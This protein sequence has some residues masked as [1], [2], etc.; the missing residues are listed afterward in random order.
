ML[1]N[2]LSLFHWAERN[3]AYF[4][5][6]ATVIGAVLVAGHYVTDGDLSQILYVLGAIL[7][8]GSPALAAANTSTKRKPQQ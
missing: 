2:L 4:Y 6:V 1:E 5:R 7:G 8:I 3:R